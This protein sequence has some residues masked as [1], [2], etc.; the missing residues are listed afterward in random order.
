MA[1]SQMGSSAHWGAATSAVR[2][3]F[4]HRRCERR[5]SAAL[6][7]GVRRRSPRRLIFASVMP[8]LLTGVRWGRIIG[9]VCKPEVTG[10]IPV[11]SINT[12]KLALLVVSVGEIRANW[13]HAARAD[14]AGTRLLPPISRK[15]C[16]RPTRPALTASPRTRIAAFCRN[17]R[18]SG[19]RAASSSRTLPA[20]AHGHAL[21]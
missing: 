10:S 21:V 19:Q 12:C 20:S 9:S 13:L 14:G 17:S 4:S 2:C 6:S 11:R 18:L 5:A 8:L 15:L 1:R 3:L 7:T 16:D